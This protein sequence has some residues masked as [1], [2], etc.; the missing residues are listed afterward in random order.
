M[1]EISELYAVK[2]G[3]STL[4]GNRML[5]GGDPNLRYPI[6]FLIYLL[7]LDGRWIL[8]DAGCLSM[9]GWE[10]RHFCHP[11]E[12]LDRLGVRAE[13]I[14]AVILTHA[15]RDHAEALSLF[16]NATVYVQQD[17][18][19]HDGGR[20]IP[21][22]RQIVPFEETLWISDSIR[23]VWIGGHAVGSSVVELYRCGEPMYVMVGDECY[24][25][26]C[27]E[28]NTPT[29]ASIDSDRS[30]VFLR[31]YRDWKRLYFHAPILPGK[32]GYLRF[33]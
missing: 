1:S 7:R 3:E 10:M 26:I 12:V 14:T 5:S 25:D 31:T 13:E 23:V 27:F 16:P 30:L 9:P 33:L 11:T 24:G 29:G 15:H 32:N 22:D 8:I 28:T 18:L 2:Y 19:T 21:Q 20:Y 4:S 17:A 6:D